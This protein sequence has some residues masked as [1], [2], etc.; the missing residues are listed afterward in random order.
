[1][2]RLR[3]A[4]GL[5]YHNSRSLLPYEYDRGAFCSLRSR[6]AAQVSVVVYA[7]YAGYAGYAEDADSARPDASRA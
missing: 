6:S 3:S 1:M 4:L 2:A 5:F 7:G